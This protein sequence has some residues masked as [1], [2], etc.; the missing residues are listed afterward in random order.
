MRRAAGGGFPPRP[1]PSRKHHELDQPPRLPRQPPWPAALPMAAPTGLP[2]GGARQFSW[3]A[4]SGTISE[5]GC[6]IGWEQRL[7]PAPGSSL[8]GG[9]CYAGARSGF[10]SLD[11]NLNVPSQN[12]SAKPPRPADAAHLDTDHDGKPNRLLLQPTRPHGRNARSGRFPLPSTGRGTEGEGWCSIE[13]S[14]GLAIPATMSRCAP[15]A[16]HRSSPARQIG[17]ARPHRRAGSPIAAAASGGGGG[18]PRGRAGL[19]PDFKHTKRKPCL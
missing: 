7:Y 4:A 17:A 8:G 15:A 12:E 11:F 13:T 3:P 19:E 9:T 18:F 5:P 16:G 1:I 6:F 10:G 2:G 14:V